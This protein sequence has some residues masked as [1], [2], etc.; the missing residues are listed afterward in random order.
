MALVTVLPI[1]APPQSLALSYRLPKRSL[2]LCM[3]VEIVHTAQQP[4]AQSAIP[5]VRPKTLHLKS[6]RK[7]GCWT[8][9]RRRR[10]VESCLGSDEM[11]SGPRL[12]IALP[13]AA[14]SHAHSTPTF[15]RLTILD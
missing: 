15:A 1:R 11:P 10:P 8:T 5:R 9:C 4:N 13:R 6:K 3:Q 12:E 14:I 2:R 7:Y